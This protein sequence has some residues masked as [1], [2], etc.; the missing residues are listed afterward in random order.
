MAVLKMKQPHFVTLPNGCAVGDL[1][2][3]LMWE[4][5]AVDKP[6]PKKPRGVWTYL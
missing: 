1:S 3:L 2:D 5:W 4:D 6:K